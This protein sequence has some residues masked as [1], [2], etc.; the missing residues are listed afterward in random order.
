[1]EKQNVDKMGGRK[2]KALRRADKAQAQEEKEALDQELGQ[3]K[4]EMGQEFEQ[5]YGFQE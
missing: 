2:S 5:T 1:L 3:E 4:T